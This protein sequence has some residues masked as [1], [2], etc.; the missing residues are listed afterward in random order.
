MTTHK[1]IETVRRGAE[2]AREDAETQHRTSEYPGYGRAVHRAKAEALDALA[3]TLDEVGE[4]PP[5]FDAANAYESRRARRIWSLKVRAAQKGAESARLSAESH[6]MG[7]RRPMGQPLVGSPARMRTQRNAIERERR[8]DERAHEAYQDAKELER[9][10]DAAEAN[11]AISSDDPEA[12]NRLREKLA[13][14]ERQREGLKAARKRP[15]VPLLNYRLAECETFT[16]ENRYHANETYGLPQV[17]MT[18]AEWKAIRWTEAK[19]SALSVDQSHRVRTTTAHYAPRYTPP[20]GD[21]TAQSN[22]AHRRVCVFFTDSKKH[23]RPT[24]GEMPKGKAN[25]LNVP[26]AWELTNLGASIRSVKERIERLEQSAAI[27]AAE[28]P[29]LELLGA[30]VE[31]WG[32]ERNRYALESNVKPPREIT[33]GLRALGLRWFRSE[34]AWVAYRNARGRHA[35]EQGA[36][37]YSEWFQ[38]RPH[39]EGNE[40]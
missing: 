40:A 23:K 15:T 11:T 25:V 16:T 36:K 24:V 28:G 35:I 26:P 32:P 12:V 39:K 29:L 8:K 30:T 27:P 5:T 34:S 6:D 14:L 22:A 37:L 3:D 31:D 21:S 38:K 13:G 10:A 4:E 20:E 33:R 9:R 19:G 2:R 1:I 17:E 7:S 18:K